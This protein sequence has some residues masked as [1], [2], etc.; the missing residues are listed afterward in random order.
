MTKYATNNPLG[1][2]D[3]K[4]LF[5]NSQNLDFAANDI[6]QAIWKDRFGRGRQTFWGMEERFN[7]FIQ[8]SG[9]K[10]IG[11]YTSGPLVITEYNQLIRYQDEFWKLTAATS[12]PFTTSGNNSASWIIDSV[13]FVSVGD[14][15]LRQEL[16]APG[17]AG[18][19]GG[20]LKPITWY[21]FAGGADP[22]GVKLSTA[23]FQA[24][25]D[26]VGYINIQPGEYLIDRSLII[27]KSA[28]IFGAGRGISK[29]KFSGD[30]STPLLKI[31]LGYA[32][33]AMVCLR[34]VTFNSTI[35][36][37]GP[38]VSIS[39]DA[40]SQAAAQVVVGDIDKLIIGNVDAYGDIATGNYWNC[41]I[42]AID[43]GGLN[44]NGFTLNNK[45]TAAQTNSATAGFRLKTTDPK[46]SVI[47]AITASN[48]YILRAYYGLETAPFSN[49][50]GGITSYYL[51]DFEIVGV[52][53]GIKAKNW[54]AAWHVTGHIDSTEQCLNFQGAALTNARFADCDLRKG[55]NGALG[56]VAGPMVTLDYGEQITF[57]G[58][59]FSGINLNLADASNVA[60]SF[61][62]AYNGSYTFLM[63]IL[64][65]TFTKFQNVLGQTNSA[66]NIVIGPNAYNQ[67]ADAITFDANLDS[68]FNLHTPI[69]SLSPTVALTVGDSSFTVDLP[70]NR[71]KSAPNYADARPV[72]NPGQA[73]RV[74]YD[75]A[76]S[77]ASKLTFRV[78]GV[79]TGGT[80]RF[81]ITTA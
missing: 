16:A 58:S 4:D 53:N 37:C 69:A 14:A 32:S 22:T 28:V 3:P 43:C 75:Y 38:L 59:T 52:K 15:A 71:F 62:N 20:L 31:S 45:T 63:S 64:G 57:S 55:N 50:A 13:H 48:F 27:A 17:G 61:T 30:A 78:Y 72:N 36:N 68:S 54:C 23:A 74:V 66:A 35:P 65:N 47:R 40:A 70:P 12:L 34:D 7:L 44:I 67:I 79:T 5:D 18:L 19:V 33:Q 6:T 29:V 25:L 46:V 51:S 8:N 42:E 60:F 81:G 24:S 21:G 9:Y 1:S 77:T 56:Y 10:V 11:D 73:I 41:G 49:A 76:A 2:T 80:F 39:T 26:Q